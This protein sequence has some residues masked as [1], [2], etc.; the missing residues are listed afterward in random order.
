MNKKRY[1]DVG[2]KIWVVK[3]KRVGKILSLNVDPENN[4][5]QAKVEIIRKDSK[6]IKVLNLWEINKY[7]DNNYPTILFAKVRPDA[8]IP[9][10]EDGNAGYD[11]YANFQEDYIILHPNTVTLVPTGIASSIKDD[12]VLVVKERGS[13]G[14]K[15]MSVRAGIV[16]ASYRGEIFVALNNTSDKSIIIAKEDSDIEVEYDG[17]IYPYSKAIAQLLLLP[18]PKA[19][20]KEIPYEE[21]KAIPSTRGTGALGSSGK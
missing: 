5:Y 17:L 15:G 13:T 9:S 6:E 7:F 19:N 10:K 1:Y 20:I 16:D 3:D 12:Y 8:I 4:I 18:V 2:E 11:L 21:L 14:S